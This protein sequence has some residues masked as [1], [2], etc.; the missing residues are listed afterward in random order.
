MPRLFL[1]NLPMVVAGWIY[2]FPKALARVRSTESEYA[3]RS[4]LA[5]RPVIDANWQTAGEP[6]PA[7]MFRHFEGVRP[8]FEQPFIQRFPPLPFERSVMTFDLDAAI[9]QSAAAEVTIDRAFLPGLPTGPMTFPSLASTPMGS[10]TISVPWT[11]SAP[12]F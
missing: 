3:V 12:R 8:T 10:F 11:L 1:D 6:G 5:G 9:L 2:A 4:L 7:A